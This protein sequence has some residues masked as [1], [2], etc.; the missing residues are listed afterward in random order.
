MTGNPAGDL[1]A[2]D[3][4]DPAALHRWLEQN[5]TLDLPTTPPKL[6]QFLGGASNLTYLVQFPDLDLVLRRPPHG[7]KAASA[8]DMGREVTVQR[9]LRPHYPL[10]PLIHGHCTDDGV[11]GSDFYVMERIAGTIMRSEAPGEVS[12][13]QATDLA[14]TV[15]DA[16]ADLHTIDPASV[17]LSEFGRGPGYVH[18]QI[19]GWSDRY[20]R[21]RTD[22]VPDGETVM[23]WL[24]EHEPT[25][26]AQ[27]LVHGDWRF[28]NLLLDLDQSRIV[29]V[30]DWEMSTIG[31]PLMDLGASLAYWVQADDDDAFLALRR[32]PTHLPG[33]PT[34]AQI[35]NR[36]AQRTGLNIDNWTFYEVYGLFRLAV[37]IQ[38]IW[39][40]YSRGESTNPAFASFGMGVNILM[41]RARS[42]IT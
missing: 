36:Y 25:D 5:T 39:Y 15:V 21:A 24:A 9:A 23:A 12:A 34:R 41:E 29:G 40:R 30:L 18:R 38:Q 31:D 28:D 32:Q 19:T 35:V 3:A 37:I 42:L 4:F 14:A 27:C 11:I 26:V 20:R 17:G 1:R 2:E 6:R 8:H 22:D 13:E 33:M 16:L 10:V 7:H